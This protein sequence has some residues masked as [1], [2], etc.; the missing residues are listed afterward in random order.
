MNSQS[1]PTYN[2]EYL[3]NSSG[4]GG[5]GGTI[6]GDGTTP[7]TLNHNISSP[8]ATATN[9]TAPSPTTATNPSTT[10]TTT[11]LSSFSYTQQI[12]K[13]PVITNTPTIVNT[14]VNTTTNNMTGAP[15]ASS[16]YISNGTGIYTRTNGD[17]ESSRKPA[18]P[19]QL[20]AGTQ[21]T[22]GVVQ[23]NGVPHS[24]FANPVPNSV[25]MPPS[26]NP[27]QQPTQTQPTQLQQQP[28]SSYQLSSPLQQPPKPVPPTPDYTK[29]QLAPETLKPA[30]FDTQFLK[31]TQEVYVKGRIMKRIETLKE[32]VP[33]IEDEA[34]KM[35][36]SIELKQ[37]TL[38]ELQ[39]KVRGEILEFS[40]MNGISASIGAGTKGQLHGGM[41][42]SQSSSSSSTRK[43]LKSDLLRGRQEISIPEQ[44]K[45]K[46]KDFLN[47]IM[48]HG[49]EF[50]EYHTNKMTKIKKISKRVTNY[51]I[52][53]EK[54]E[55]Q[56]KEKEERERLRALK[57]ND[58]SK[59]LKLLEQ[60][61]NKRLRELFD[62]TN[63]FLDK[64]SHLLQKE[65]TQIE[66]EEENEEAKRLLEAN[67]AAASAS[68]NNNNSAAPSTSTTTT[69]AANDSEVSEESKDKVEERP[70]EEKPKSPSDQRMKKT[71]KMIKKKK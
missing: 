39:R 40:D 5:G 34:A 8:V 70:D 15:S 48:Q 44:E 30:Q 21:Q 45:T 53:Q 65:K 14:G 9:S 38:L 36:T 7:T 59:Y 47:A 54:K 51:F 12:S 3:M 28:P 19:A 46:Q 1:P 24:S 71:K 64:I 69:S 13:P 56:Q 52:L 60:T 57:Q 41:L 26:S 22:P 49:R 35:Q 6:V 32:L 16:N 68:N 2:N 23:T 10:T 31:E 27:G 33:T 66:E 25:V 37:L 42:S 50:K 62:Q 63:E 58:E 11:G 29:L 18:V 67:A 4:G 20:G 43:K 61:K 17:F 55:Q